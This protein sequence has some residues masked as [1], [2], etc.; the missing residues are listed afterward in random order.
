MTD[1]KL[2]TLRCCM[3]DKFY[4]TAFE[5]SGVFKRIKVSHEKLKYSIGEGLGFFIV[6]WKIGKSFIC[7]F[8]GS[9]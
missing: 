5:L 3:E 2:S 1:Q 8:N 7:Y 9:T 4:L 6:E